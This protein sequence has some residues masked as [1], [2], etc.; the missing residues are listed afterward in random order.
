[1]E[2]VENI[3]INPTSDEAAG[4]LGLIKGKAPE[5]TLLAALPR[6][7]SL[8]LVEHRRQQVGGVVLGSDQLADLDFYELAGEAADGLLVCQPILLE[9]EDPEKGEFVRKFEQFSKRSPDWIAVADYDAMRLAL[10]VLKRS[11][12][13]RASFLEVI[14]EIS[15]PD[16]AFSGLGGPVFFKQDGT[17]QRP[18]FMAEI[19]S[20]RL[21]PARPPTVE[22]PVVLSSEK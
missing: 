10:E 1:M 15:G 9:R 14:R 16:R 12:P 8:F 17:S 19:H 7:A 4:A 6:T 13:E 18:F 21:R 11:G 22:F 3:S 5:A 2:L 20:G